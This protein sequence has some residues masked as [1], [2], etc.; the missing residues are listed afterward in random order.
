MK[1]IYITGGTTDFLQK[2]VEENKSQD[3]LVLQDNDDQSLLIHESTGEGV[4]QEG[5]EYEIIDETGE[6]RKTGYAVLNNIPVTDEGRPLF[7]YRFKNRARMVEDEQGFIA[8]RVLR[9]LNSDTYIILTQWETEK[10]FTN[11]QTSKA[12]DHAHKKR[13]T[14]EGV[15]QQPIFPRPSYA[16]KYNVI[17]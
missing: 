12:Y 6:L 10:D 8:I 1:K 9:P 7:E 17:E 16:T 3:F 2:I 14:S 4:F 5:R 11:W 15:D 13:G